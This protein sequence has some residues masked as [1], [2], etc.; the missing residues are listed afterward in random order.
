MVGRT[1]GMHA[2]PTTF[3]TKLALSC[4]QADRDRTRLRRAREADRRRQALGRRRHVL[5]HRAGGRGATSARRSACSPFPPPRCIA[6]DRHAEYLYACAAARHDDRDRSRPRSATCS[7]PRWA[8]SRSR[9]APARRARRRCRT[10]ETRS[11]PS[12]SSVW[13]GCC[14]ATSSPAS[15]TWRSGTSGTSPTAR[16][17]G[18]CCPDASLVAY[19]A[20]SKDDPLD[21]R[22]RRP[23]R[24]HAR[25]PARGLARPRLLPAGAA[26]AR[27]LGPHPRRRLPHRAARR[28]H[29]PRRSGARSGPC[30]TT[31]PEV[32]A[33]LGGAEQAAKS[34]DEAFDL[35][36][37]LRTCPPHV[38]RPRAGR[39]G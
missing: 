26:R 36:R 31:D 24:P 37:S 13:P 32:A 27:R 35:D 33:A 3:G 29:A 2:E 12:A 16:S 1:H 25:E 6:R 11:P 15:K 22:A 18:S 34:L 17:S 23:R 28:P 8:R 9:S 21:R 4:L 20:A 30:S 5:Q 10:S 39:A 7:A 19:Y 38:R 14:A